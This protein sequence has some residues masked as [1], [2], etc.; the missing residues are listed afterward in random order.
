[1]KTKCKTV[2]RDP[3]KVIPERLAKLD[4]EIANGREALERMLG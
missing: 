3:P 2:K 1:M 4:D